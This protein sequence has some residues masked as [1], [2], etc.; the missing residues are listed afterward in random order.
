MIDRE[1][2]VNEFHKLEEKARIM[3]LQESI[4]VYLIGGGN[5]ALR[6]IKEATKDIDIIVKN[7][8]QYFLLT[9]VF[10]TSIPGKPIYIKQYK[11]EWDYD[12][13]MNVRYKLSLTCLLKEF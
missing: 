13:G 9:K 1:Y 4:N 7:K 12:L 11:S 6:G 2:I 5:L 3:N 8:S 10:E